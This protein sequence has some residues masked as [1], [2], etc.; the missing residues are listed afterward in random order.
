M[1]NLGLYV[2][3]DER[4]YLH[5]YPGKLGVYIVYSVDD[6]GSRC[7]LCLLQSDIWTYVHS[8]LSKHGFDA[9]LLGPMKS[10]CKCIEISE[11]LFIGHSIPY[12]GGTWL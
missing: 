11:L 3:G 4:L 9:C 1:A 10:Q 5:R 6:A 7:P 12:I 2:E 8:L